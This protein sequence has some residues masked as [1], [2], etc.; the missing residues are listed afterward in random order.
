MTLIVTLT[1]A[2]RVL[3]RIEHLKLSFGQ[4]KYLEG[5]NYFHGLVKVNGEVMSPSGLLKFSATAHENTW[6]LFNPLTRNDVDEIF[7]LGFF[8]L[9]REFR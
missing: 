5:T 9:N 4:W 1:P 6:K 2:K 3:R 8:F 7:Y